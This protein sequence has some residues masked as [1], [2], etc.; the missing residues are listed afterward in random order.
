MIAKRITGMILAVQ[1]LALRLAAALC[2]IAN[3]ALSEAAHVRE[4]A[5][6]RRTRL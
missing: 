5:E 6:R 3:A 1:M 4:M 2:G